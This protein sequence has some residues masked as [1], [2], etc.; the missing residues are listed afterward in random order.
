MMSNS[1]NGSGR[2]GFTPYNARRLAYARRRPA[3]HLGGA[4]IAPQT[5]EK[6][7]MASGITSTL[8]RGPSNYVVNPGDL[9]VVGLDT[10]HQRGEHPL[11]DKRAF[12]AADESMVT[13]I[14]AHGVK[15]AIFVR[16][17][18]DVLEVIDGRRRVINAREAN[19]RIKEDGSDRPFI[20]VPVVVQKGTDA[21]LFGLA[22]LLNRG[23]L[24]EDAVTTADAAQRLIDMG[25]TKE[26][27][28]AYL[29]V[30]VPM[31]EIYL[32]L[33]DLDPKIQKAIESGEISATAASK[34][35]KLS[36]DEQIVAFDSMRAA[37]TLSVAAANSVRAA[38][39]AEKKG[40]AREVSQAPKKSIVR[41]LVERAESGD[42]EVD[43]SEDF[44]LG[45]K[46]AIG[47]ADTKKIKGLS[48]AVR[49]VAP[50][51]REKTGTAE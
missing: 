33:L 18:G 36:R 28:A 3:E 17:N 20:E 15:K 39:V 2:N 11:W 40:S 45:I 46:W 31:L 47:L 34:L 49:A 51:K 50:K 9:C 7:Y 8:K 16:V 43:L 41:R 1:D 24:E 38:K 32:S 21:H 37:G 12:L 48:A 14:L 22:R 25:K 4:G 29:H 10:P 35:S 44:L 6:A 30:G 19:R 23:N 26:E 5:Q 42:L 27:V 13:S